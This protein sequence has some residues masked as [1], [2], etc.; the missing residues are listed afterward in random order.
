MK[1]L[2]ELFD[3]VRQLKTDNEML[4][5]TLK[6]YIKLTKVNLNEKQIQGYI[7]YMVVK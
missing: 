5:A 1:T 7:R 3:E 2:E 4:R 6:K